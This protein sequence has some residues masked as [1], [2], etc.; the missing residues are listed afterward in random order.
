MSHQIKLK[1]FFAFQRERCRDLEGGLLTF[2]EWFVLL[3]L[4]YLS[5]ITG[6]VSIPSYEWLSSRLPVEVRIGGPAVRKCLVKL[7]NHKL[8]QYSNKRGSRSGFK[9][10]IANWPIGNGLARVFEEPENHKSVTSESSSELQQ[11]I[12]VVVDNHKSKE[13][14]R[15]EIKPYSFNR[16]GGLVTSAKTETEKEIENNYDRISINKKVKVSEF[17]PNSAVDDKLHQIA[18]LIGEE[19]MGFVF[20]VYQERRDEGIWTMEKLA[21]D[22]V[23]KPSVRDKRAYFNAEV[24]RLLRLNPKDE[25]SV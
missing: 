22:L 21:A 17:V 16:V 23:D 4:H 18:Q 3:W 7:Q 2:S 15:N 14:I 25:S 6:S 9:V 10:K 19:Y 12:E 20:W 13:R 11:K 8:I 24:C 1:G 5:D